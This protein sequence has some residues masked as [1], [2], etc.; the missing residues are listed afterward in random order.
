MCNGTCDD[1][2]NE[3]CGSHPYPATRGIGT[4]RH[5]CGA[6]PCHSALGYSCQV[7]TTWRGVPPSATITKFNTCIIL[8]FPTDSSSLKRPFIPHSTSESHTVHLALVVNL[9][10]SLTISTSAEVVL[11]IVSR[12]YSRAQRTRFDIVRYIIVYHRAYGDIV[13][14][15]GV[16]SPMSTA[17]FKPKG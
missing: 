12:N 9:Q 13:L 4:C 2:S 14:G 17:E 11:S 16:G 15:R 10:W 5:R 6:I 1:S 7:L 8:N 3:Y